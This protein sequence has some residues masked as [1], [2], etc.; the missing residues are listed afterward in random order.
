[1]PTVTLP[2]IRPTCQDP[3]VKHVTYRLQPAQVRRQWI[4]SVLFLAQ[5]AWLVYRGSLVPVDARTAVGLALGVLLIVFGLFWARGA[6][7]SVSFDGREIWWTGV[8]G[9]RKRFAWA[10]VTNVEVGKNR[11]RADS[12]DVVRITHRDL[13]DFKLPAVIGMPRA[14]RDPGFEAKAAHI[15][16]TWR[17]AVTATSEPT[18]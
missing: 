12:G 6:L 13:G 11:D 9:S 10:D 18:A 2:Q 8:L 3:L 4:F 5:G 7:S 1:M 15:I 14:W 16:A 17:D